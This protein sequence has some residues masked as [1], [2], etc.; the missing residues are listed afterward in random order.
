LKTFANI[1]LSNL[2]WLKFDL[3]FISLYEL[4]IIFSFNFFVLK[5]LDYEMSKRAIIH[6]DF[7]KHF[8]KY[9]GFK[10]VASI[11]MANVI[12]IIFKFKNRI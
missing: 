2:K 10:K 11:K 1:F 3:I 8:S 4:Q 9:Y 12:I 5:V 7:I 6:M